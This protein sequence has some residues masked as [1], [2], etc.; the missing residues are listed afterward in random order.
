MNKHNTIAEIQE[1]VTRFRDERDWIQFHN[2]KDLSVS[3]AIEASELLEIFQWQKSDMVIENSDNKKERICDE[4][5]D[6]VIYC[7]FL[8]DVLGIDLGVAVASKVNKNSEKYPIEK[9]FGNARKY[10]SS[11]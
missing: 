4:V 7:L 6:V 11:E 5:A 8:C 3:I 2:P 1:L 10:N 9:S